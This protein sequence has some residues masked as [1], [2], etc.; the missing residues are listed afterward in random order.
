MMIR[1]R[2]EE[3]NCDEPGVQ[4]A[5]ELAEASYGMVAATGVET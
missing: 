2:A 5:T 1:S 4:P 3:S